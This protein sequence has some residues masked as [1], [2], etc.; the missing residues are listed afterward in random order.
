MRRWTERRRLP[1]E[2]LHFP[3]E[4]RARVRPTATETGVKDVFPPLYNLPAI[5]TTA[6]GDVMRETTLL[7]FAFVAFV[8]IVTPGPTVLL[9]QT[10]GS[11]YGM[12][13]AA[14]GFAGAVASDVVLIAAVAQG[15]GALLAASEF[16]FSV[17]KWVGAAYLAYV[18]VRLRLS[19]GA[20]HATPEGAAA[21]GDSNRT[22]FLKSFLTAVT[23]PK[24]YLFFSAFLPQFITPSAAQA[25]Q[26]F[27]LAVT[28]AGLDLALMS[29]YALLGARAIRL[30]TKAGARWLDRICGGVLVAL[31]G[32]LALYRRNS[33]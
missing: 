12:R 4:L 5:P 15:L 9:A 33:A 32:T 27:A 19:K 8:G 24:G 23:N 14:Y 11:R 26:Y 10:N 1:L 13:R 28:F 6:P 20:L 29:G 17:V 21:S 2:S 7:L 30:L 31:A 25:P 22:I 16:W 3:D 18:G